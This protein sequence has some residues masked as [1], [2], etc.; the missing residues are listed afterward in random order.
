MALCSFSQGYVSGTHAVRGWDWTQAVLDD[1]LSGWPSQ[2]QTRFLLSLPAEQRV[3][4]FV[5]R[6][7]AEVA[8]GY[9]TEVSPYSVR[10]SYTRAARELLNHGRP[11][12]ALDLLASQGRSSVDVERVD[13]MTDG[14]RSAAFTEPGSDR[15]STYAAVEVLDD[16]E[17]SA[18][19]DDETLASLEFI[20]WAA[21]EAHDRPARAIHRLLCSDPNFFATLVGFA[22][23]THRNGPEEEAEIDEATRRA[24]LQRAQLTLEVLDSWRTVPGLTADGQIDGE[25]LRQWI[26]EGR[27]ILEPAGLL[28]PAD[29]H[30][31]SLL[32]FSPDSDGQWPAPVVC[33]IIEELRSID[34]EEGLESAIVVLRETTRGMFDGGEQER[35]LAARYREHAA[36]VLG[37][38]RTA[39]MLRRIAD[40][41]EQEARTEDDRASLRQDIGGI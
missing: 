4:E 11:W 18:L 17:G 39:S 41:F 30:I 35:V 7:D 5:A 21:L 34:L 13:V 24:I 25:R 14:L 19:V 23:S 3:W 6:T 16:L 38:P 26:L 9:W 8:R 37:C 27:T 29:H 12:A 40:A 22:H 20:W 10:D 28:G 15:A 2:G 33:D 31:G 1:R 36:A 32:A